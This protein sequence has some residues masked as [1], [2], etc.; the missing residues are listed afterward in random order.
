LDT[1]IKFGVAAKENIPTIRALDNIRR[2]FFKIKDDT[3]F[4]IYEEAETDIDNSIC[5]SV[6][7]VPVTPVTYDRFHRTIRNPFKF[8]GK[9]IALRVDIGNNLIELVSEKNI[10]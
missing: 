7:T 10:N 4:I 2:Q 1:L 8:K 6:I 3:W 9:R 5:D